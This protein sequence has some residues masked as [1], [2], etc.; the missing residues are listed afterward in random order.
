MPRGL[1]QDLFQEQQ[2]G[3][4]VPAFVGLD[5]HSETIRVCVM[6]QDGDV[7]ANRNVCNCTAAVTD[8]VRA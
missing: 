3:T 5:D 4:F 7:L 1:F 6:T 8:L 2:T